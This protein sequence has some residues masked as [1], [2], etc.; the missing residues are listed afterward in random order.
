MKSFQIT[1]FALK[2]TWQGQTV[3]VNVAN[4][5]NLTNMC[6]QNDFHANTA[7]HALTAQTFEPVIAKL[8]KKK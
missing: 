1:K 8:L 6:T 4:A 7:G 3:P 5:C 2:G